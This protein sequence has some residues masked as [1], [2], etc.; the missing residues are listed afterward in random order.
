MRFAS[1]LPIAALSMVTMA[2]AAD[3][4]AVL[5]P[6]RDQIQ[7]SDYRAA[8]QIVRVEANG[9]RISYAI[10]VK[11]LWFAGAMHTLVDVVPPKSSA[12]PARQNDR[13]RLLLEMRPDGRDSIRI[14]RPGDS[15]PK[16]LPF[17]EWSASFLDTAFSYEDLLDQQ[18]FWPGQTILKSAVFGTHQ[19]NVLKSTPGATDRTNYSEVQTWLDRVINYPVYAE[20][21][22]KQGG[23]VKEFTYFGLRQS[24]GVWSA[25]QV[26][27]KVRG[28]EESAFLTIK[29][30][31]AKANLS[32][33]DFR[34]DQ[35]SHFADHP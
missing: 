30:G 3:V 2:H 14:F 9:K 7:A 12:G 33:S 29:R 18:Y 10:S 35:I 25:T 17:D 27:V 8:G 13:M 26:E 6:L 4:R 31:S 11:G 5:T 21:M 1:A 20:K 23:T 22:M 16:E 32:A 28:R 34:L 24:S 19:C 15:A